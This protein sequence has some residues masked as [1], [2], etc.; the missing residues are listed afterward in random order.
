M[1]WVYENGE[2]P[3]LPGL[4][5]F[6]QRQLFWI[7]NAHRFCSYH[8]NKWLKRAMKDSHTPNK[9][10]LLGSMMLSDEFARDFNCSIKTPMNPIKRCQTGSL[11]PHSPL[12]GLEARRQPKAT[13]EAGS[14]KSKELSDLL[15]LVAMNFLINAFH[16]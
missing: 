11:W 13:N 8:S 3:L 12:K 15:I 9:Y 6:N 2:E 14:F 7:R 5:D 1:L 16:Q 10:R 4:T